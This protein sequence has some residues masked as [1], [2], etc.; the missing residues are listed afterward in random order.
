MTCLTPWKPCWKVWLGTILPSRTIVALTHAANDKL[1]DMIEAATAG[2]PVRSENG[3]IHQIEA[4]IHGQQETTEESVSVVP[5]GNAAERLHR[6]LIEES[7]QSLT[8]I[9]W[10]ALIAGK[11]VTCPP[12]KLFTTKQKTQWGRR[13]PANV[14]SI[15]RPA[16]ALSRFITQEK[17][18]AAKDPRATSRQKERF[19]I[20][21]ALID[22][23]ERWEWKHRMNWIEELL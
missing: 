3:M 11:W 22:Q 8:P 14:P 13:E 6:V 2:S 12:S 7:R 15:S 18:S 17:Q 9:W 5:E 16:D 1:V 19:A 23:I 21:V 4:L 20:W 10:E